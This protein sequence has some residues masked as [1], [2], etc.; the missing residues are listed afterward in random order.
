[1]TLPDNYKTWLQLYY[2]LLDHA[3]QHSIKLTDNYRI[4]THG[5]NCRFYS[6]KIMVFDEIIK[7]V[8]NAK[9]ARS[10]FGIYQA[11]TSAAD[12]NV[13]KLIFDTY[14]LVSTSE[15]TQ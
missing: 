12:S 3:E 5:L 2:D 8:P 1:M 6:V 7:I 4:D 14:Q 9:Q 15:K 10:L 11:M 13:L